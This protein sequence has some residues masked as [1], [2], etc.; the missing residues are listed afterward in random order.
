[1]KSFVVASVALLAVVAVVGPSSGEAA[2]GP[3]S[4]RILFWTKGADGKGHIK[5]MAPDGS[6]RRTVPIPDGA[7][8]VRLSP[9]GR[10]ILFTTRIEDDVPEVTET[11]WRLFT[12]RS[13]G[14]QVREIAE[15][16]NASWS[17]SG[18]EIIYTRYNAA[19]DDDIWVM[20][21][22]GTDARA[23]F[24]GPQWEFLPEWSPDG[25]TIAFLSAS[26]GAPAAGSNWNIYLMDADGSDVREL[27]E[28]PDPLIS[29]QGT[30]AN[31]LEWSPDSKKLAYSSF[32]FQEESIDIFIVRVDG[33]GT[34]RVTRGPGAEWDPVWSPD[35]RRLLFAGD[36][37]G[38]YDIYSMRLSDR[39]V[40]KLTNNSWNDTP[41][42]WV[43]P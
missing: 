6:A 12:A 24:T 32:N 34:R 37:D 2:S 23:L 33:S 9:D 18:G 29:E 20:N 10:S 40:R 43:A 22:D 13:D 38:D 21:S 14:S 30:W 42:D 26:K 25:K 27:T 31:G 39:K 3:A 17:P 28:F 5:T 41:Y 19:T 8:E 35:G 11:G 16:Y 36:K 15:G 4:E 1:M 7:T